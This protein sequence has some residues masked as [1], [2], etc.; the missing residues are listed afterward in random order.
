MCILPQVRC[1][2]PPFWP[3]ALPLDLTYISLVPSTVFRDPP[4][5]KLLTFQ[6][7]NLVSV[8]HS[9]GRLTKESVQVRGSLEVFVASFFYGEGLLTPR[10]TPK[11]E[12]HPL[13]SVRDCLF[14]FSQLTFI[15]G[16]RSSIRNPRMSH[17]VGIG[18]PP[19]RIRKS[20]SLKEM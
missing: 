5:Y 10:P 14:N 15:A 9:L 16:G 2:R 8:F 13:S 7:P 19:N 4:L 20:L 6:V 11:L 18:T 12:G 3:P 1:H 17:A